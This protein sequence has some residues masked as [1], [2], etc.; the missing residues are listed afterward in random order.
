MMPT[1]ARALRAAANN[2]SASGWG[3]RRRACSRVMSWMVVIP[4]P[5]I[6]PSQ[7]QKRRVF[8]ASEV[9]PLNVTG[10]P[11]PPCPTLPAHSSW[12]PY[13]VQT[14]PSAL[15]LAVR[16]GLA[17]GPLVPCDVMVG[18]VSVIVAGSARSVRVSW[19][20]LHRPHQRLPAMAEVCPRTPLLTHHSSRL[21]HRVPPVPIQ[22]LLPPR[23][24]Q[25]LAS[26]PHVGHEI[27]VK[28][29]AVVSAK[30]IGYVG[31]SRCLEC[32]HRTV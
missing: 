32:N 18:A 2:W 30:S 19:S 4:T 29:V 21:H 20:G 27:R 7:Q 11:R 10:S 9:V 26:L 23:R 13:Q 28:D 1:L 15:V 17:F 12:L 22:P 24:D 16:F 6:R 31:S 8:H 5:S 3:R 14:T 25:M